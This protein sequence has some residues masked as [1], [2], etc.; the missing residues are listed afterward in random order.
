MDDSIRPTKE[1]KRLVSTGTVTLSRVKDERHRALAIAW[2]NLN[3]GNADGTEDGTVVVGALVGATEVG[4]LVGTG[5]SE[6][7]GFLVGALVGAFVTGAGVTGTTGAFVGA[8]V[9]AFVTGAG[10]TGT[11]GAFVGAFVTG[12]GVAGTGVAVEVGTIVV[13][14]TVSSVG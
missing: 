10:V 14:A 8:M 9:G 2:T 12:A 7:T 4:G 3:E 6:T 13:G 1:L 11:T 5:V